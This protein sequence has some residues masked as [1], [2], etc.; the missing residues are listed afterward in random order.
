MP[1]IFY[2]S[3][4]TCIAIMALSAWYLGD[5]DKRIRASAR[6][7]IVVGGSTLLVVSFFFS[8]IFMAVLIVII[9]IAL[10]SAW[11]NGAF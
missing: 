4:G 11:W 6:V 10:I 5:E 3:I 7:G 1:L 8:A 9:P 2:V